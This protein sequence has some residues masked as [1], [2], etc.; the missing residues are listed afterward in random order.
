MK[1]FLAAAV[2][3]S[4]AL[5]SLAEDFAL[6]R[7]YVGASAAL[8]LPQGGS[9]MRRIGGAAARAGYYFND[10]FALECEA[11]RLE[12]R[13]ALAARGVWHAQGWEWFGRLF[14]YERLDP[15][16][17]LGARGWTPNGQ[18]GPA[19]GLGAFYY[20]GDAWAVRFDAEFELGLDTRAETSHTLS[21]GL[22]YSF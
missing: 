8:T 15:F 7:R 17:T 21:L 10:N 18:V 2:F 22:Q 3:A 6:P 5:L 12:D 16:A 20:L 9:R 13:T 14:G 11:G 19:F 1:R 4:A